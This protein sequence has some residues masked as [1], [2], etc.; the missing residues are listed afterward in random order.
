METI[1][2]VLATRM[3]TVPHTCTVA[4]TTL[5]SYEKWDL[6]MKLPF[7]KDLIGRV[8]FSCV[9]L[10]P[11]LTDEAST[12][13]SILLGSAW[14]SIPAYIASATILYASSVVVYRRWLHP[15]AEIPGP[16]WASVSRFY[17]VKY[18]LFSERSQ[19]YLH[20]EKLHQHYGTK[21]TAVFQ[22][23]LS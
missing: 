22:L 9:P 13:T 17:I 21:S 4:N 14:I 8:S 6:L 7:H 2:P 15:L 19:F 11:H 3:Q 23:D 18:N 12:M 10:I 20:V 16:F 5:S 1:H